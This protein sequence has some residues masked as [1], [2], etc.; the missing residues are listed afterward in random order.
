MKLFNTI[1]TLKSKFGIKDV[2][3]SMVEAVLES[4]LDCI[5]IADKTGHIIEFNPASEKTFGFS[6]SEVIGKSLAETIIPH[7]LRAAHDEGMAT[8][9]KTGFQ[10]VIGQRI[11]VPAL[12]KT[13]TIFPVELAIE[14]A[15]GANGDTIF[16]AYMRDITDRKNYEERLEE[17][18]R[19]AEA[20]NAAKS[21]FLAMMS[22]EIRTPLNGV[23]GVLGLL[24]DSVLN[25]EQDKY[26]QIGRNSAETLL[27]VINDVLDFSKMEAGKLT[28]ESEIFDLH[29]LINSVA[30]IIRPRGQIKELDLI[31]DIDDEVPRWIE[32][33]SG[34]IRQI[35][36]NLAGNAVKFT[37]SGYVKIGVK[38][39]QE[40]LC[41]FVEDTGIGI[42][43]DKHG[44]LFVEFS[45]LDSS[46]S[47]KFE[48]TGLGLAISKKLTEL[49]SGEINFESVENEGSVFYIHLPLTEANAPQEEVLTSEKDFANT[50]FQKQRILVAEDNPA[51]VII[52]KAL[53]E[54]LNLTVDIANDGTEAVEA[55]RRF[56]YDLV[57]MDIAMPE[58]DGIEA[59]GAIRKLPTGKQIPIVAMTAHAM[60]G[61]K[62]KVLDAGMDDYMRKPVRRARLLEVLQD[63]LETTSTAS[64]EPAGSDT[65]GQTPLVNE[66]L[67]IF[68]QTIL[69]Q[70]EVDVGRDIVPELADIYF[71]DSL[72]RIEAMKQAY[73]THDFQTLELESHTLAS[74]SAAYGLNALHDCLRSIETAVTSKDDD[75]ALKQTKESFHIY[76]QSMEALKNYLAQ[77]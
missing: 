55:V 12:H 44:E 46:Y 15:Q 53:L 77:F 47:R 69:K 6:R 27:N 17:S 36:I 73:K 52:I 25:K 35:L 49:M 21:E 34:R 43:H 41:F 68:D 37:Q 61:Y 74:S 22:H 40:K 62:Q 42:P 56:P 1:S 75:T 19:R 13:G 2:R 8:Y 65:S 30:D 26:V 10:K 29:A 45:M 76:D 51:N 18:K 72:K 59:T 66:Q 70:L 14:V 58:M 50:Q 64:F 67:S 63:Y 24:D 4:S 7:D 48:G 57:F 32:A 3:S 16:V 54:K 71:K 20:A 23:I 9:H 60:E 11:E 5:I 31:I 33:D 28:L 38:Q 39:A